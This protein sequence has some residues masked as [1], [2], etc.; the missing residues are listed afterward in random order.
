MSG[1]WARPDSPPG[2]WVVDEGNDG[3]PGLPVMKG[4]RELVLMGMYEFWWIRYFKSRRTLKDFYGSLWKIP[5]PGATL[6]VLAFL[7]LGIYG[8]VFWL[9][10]SAVILGIGHVGIHLQHRKEIKNDNH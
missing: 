9:V 2:K 8:K 7:L 4:N 1:P 5:V 6:P 3:T 10:L